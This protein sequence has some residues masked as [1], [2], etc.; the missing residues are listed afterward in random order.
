[1]KWTMSILG[2]IHVAGLWAY[3]LELCCRLH[4]AEPVHGGRVSA[5][6]VVRRRDCR[7][8][9]RFNKLR[10]VADGE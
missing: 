6:R 10:G 7:H 4:A 5:W 8:W 1:M 9:S 2:P 3:L